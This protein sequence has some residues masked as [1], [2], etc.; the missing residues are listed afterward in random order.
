MSKAESELSFEAKCKEFICDGR[1]GVE[2]VLDLGM[3]PPS[4]RLLTKETL[5]EPERKFPLQVVFCPD[6]YLVRILEIV[7]PEFLFGD[8]YLYFSSFSQH[9]LDHSREN[10]LDIIKR[11]NLSKDNLVVELASNDGYLLKNF[12][13]EGIPVLGIDP[14][15][16][17]V[18]AANKAGVNSINE[19][20]SSELA[21][22]LKSEGKQA[23][24]IIGNNVLAHVADTHDFVDGISTLLK[25]DGVAVME[26][27]YVRDLVDHT[28]FDTIYHEHLCYFS[29]IA[30]DKLFRKH[31]M[32]VNDV[33]RVKIH[34][35]SIRIYVEKHEAPTDNLKKVM[36]EE[37]DLGM[38]RIEYYQGFAEKVAKI[39][40][41]LRKLV[42]DLKSE[43]KRIAAYGAAAKG[44]IMLNYCGIDSSVIDYVVDRNVH[45]HGKFMPG[46]H[47]EIL[48][49]E[50]ILEDMPDYVVLLPWNFSDEILKQQSEYREKGGKFIIPVPNVRIV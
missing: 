28:E 41:D 18:E 22:K 42:T 31:G 1:K 36:A 11:R 29:V 26:M 48:P 30:V 13:Q 15:P 10:A 7:P 6:S 47:I 12:V 39:R 33:K 16:N 21:K 3:M 43:G 27:H 20:F 32:F 17:Q 40:T 50:K 8:E 34:G 46:V 45:K 14:A 35:G 2:P 19:F 49:P 25:E 37:Y 5:K 38:D 4:D 44:T 9:L 24:V 23:D